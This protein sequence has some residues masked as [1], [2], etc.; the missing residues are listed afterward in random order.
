[1]NSLKERDRLV[2]YDRRIKE[3]PRTL[4][5]LG[6]EFNVSKERIRQIEEKAFEKIQLEVKRLSVHHGLCY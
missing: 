1:M 4:E 3:P 6:K 5:D 2:F